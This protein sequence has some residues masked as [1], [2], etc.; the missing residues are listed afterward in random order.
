[1]MKHL[2]ALAQLRKYRVRSLGVGSLGVDC[3]IDLLH[4]KDLVL[5][6]LGGSTEVTK[7]CLHVKEVVV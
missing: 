2:K 3:E 5:N 6:R 4:E 7:R 1:M